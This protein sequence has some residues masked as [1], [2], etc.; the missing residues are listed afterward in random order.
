LFVERLQLQDGYH[1]SFAVVSCNFELLL[2]VMTLSPAAWPNAVVTLQDS[3]AAGGNF[4]ASC[5]LG[6]HL[7]VWPVINNQ[8]AAAAAA[9]WLASCCSPAK[10]S[11]VCSTAAAA[12]AAC[13]TLLFAAGWPHAV[14]T[15]QDSLAVGGNFLTSCHLARH[16]AVFQLEQRLKVKPSCQ[17]PGFRQLMWQGARHLLA[18]LQATVTAAVGEVGSVTRKQQQQPEVG[19]VLFACELAGLQDL[20]QTLQQWLDEASQQQQQQQQQEGDGKRRTRGVD[21]AA[22][23]A[24]AT[25]AAVA[26]GVPGALEDPAGALLTTCL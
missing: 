7:A 8:S 11:H 14:V 24:A 25:A 19:G 18:R 21:A 23:A 20:L 5:H 17:Y 10:L 16:L 3:L 12:A 22:A 26:A 6:R 1:L 15:L 4:L 9:C 13:C 2:C